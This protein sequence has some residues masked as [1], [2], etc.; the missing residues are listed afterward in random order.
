M[1]ANG[2]T[3]ADVR[4]DFAPLRNSG[5]TSGAAVAVQRRDGAGCAR[6]STVVTVVGVVIVTNVTN[7]TYRG[8][9]VRAVAPTRGDMKR[10]KLQFV[11]R[12][13][14]AWRS[15]ARHRVRAGLAGGFAATL[16]L[17][18][19]LGTPAAAASFPSWPEVQAAKANSA[20]AAAAVEN[21]RALIVQLDVAAQAAQAESEKRSTE[22][23]IAQDKFDLATETAN[24]L[25]LQADESKAQA[26]AATKQAGQLAAQLY[27]SGGG[28]LSVNLMLEG[29]AKSE[30]GE[31]AADG[32]DSLLSR[33][34]SMSKMV[35]RSTGIYA[36]AQTTTNTAAALSD[37][38]KIATVEREK[39]RVAAEAALAAAVAAQQAADAALAESQER[40][41][42]LDA[43]LAFMLD[44]E[45]KTTAA[46]EEGERQRIAAE[47]AAAAARAAAEA[48]AGG[49][50]GGGGPGPGLGGG[51]INNGWAVPA[52]GRITDN[53]GPRPVICGPEG[54]SGNYHRGTD[55]GTGC[56]APIYAA[57]SGTVIYSGRNGTYGNWIEIDHGGGIR[58]GYAHIR[59]GGRFVGVGDWVNVGQN[60][61][62][63]GT[64]GAS[65]GC[66]LHFE[67]YINN[68][69][70]DAV[71][72]MA[73]RGVPLG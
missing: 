33:L 57:S 26:D 5:C 46:Y 35:E 70:S 11:R 58:T 63:S 23:L 19:A 56:S 2:V 1:L 38:A 20:N 60:I 17:T 73:A 61:A 18:L 25:Q 68:N 40:S 14:S 47:K 16:T 50:G 9:T 29:N 39:L 6:E 66:H 27:R 15:I 13:K 69:R 53:F 43:Q 67:V 12:S 71:P 36:S 22:F 3:V 28:D 34:G 48:A 31:S 21:I 10:T 51:Y 49:G 52:S 37:Q 55:I 44:A 72:F 30:S 42:V 59:D 54:C 62:S 8:C 45:A 64:T 4:S 32:A 41:V 7:V 65:N 24:A